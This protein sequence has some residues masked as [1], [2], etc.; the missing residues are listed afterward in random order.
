MHFR[1]SSDHQPE[2][3]FVL[4][5]A[6]APARRPAFPPWR[7]LAWIDA[8]TLAGI[9]LVFVVS[10]VVWMV[11]FRLTPVGLVEAL[12]Q[13]DCNWYMGVSAHGYALEPHFDTFQADWAFFPAYP[14]AIW[15]VHSLTGLSALV[16]GTLISNLAIIAGVW[17]GCRYLERTRPGQGKAGFVVLTLAGPYSFYFSTVY[18]EGLFFL[19]AVAAFLLWVSDRPILA[20][21]AAGLLSASRAIG[22]FIAVAFFIDLLR[23]YGRAAPRRL[24]EHPQHL[25]ALLL[26]PVGLFGYMLFLHFRVGDALAFSHVQVAWGREFTVPLVWLAAGLVHFDLPKLLDIHGYSYFYSSCWVLVGLG[27]C[28]SLALRRRW[29]ELTFALVC[30]FVPLSTGLTSMPRY[31]A[32]CPVLLFAA[33]DL[34]ARFRT[35]GPATLIL[36]AAGVV[37]LALLHGWFVA[38]VSMI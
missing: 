25:V 32:T 22:V 27:L 15:I 1:P 30:L 28:T 21:T 4:D 23:R 24:L 17:L 5:T 8:G 16:A 35:R 14:L 37:N 12:C 18:S 20:G 31:V 11:L 33:A 10:R 36:V 34:L 26:V 6:D 29:M 3:T 9:V 38:S 13:W 7:P 19:F 2:G